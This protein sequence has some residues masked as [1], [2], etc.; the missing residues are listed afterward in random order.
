MNSKLLLCLALV[1]S[2]GLFGCSITKSALIAADAEQIKLPITF[3]SIGDFFTFVARD[4]INGMPINDDTVSKLVADSTDKIVVLDSKQRQMPF[5]HV[6]ESH[7][8]NRGIDEIR[9]VQGNGQFYILRPLASKVE[10]VGILDGNSYRL[11]PIN[12]TPRFVSYW[13]LSA[14][15][16]S[17]NI[18]EWNGK[19]FEQKK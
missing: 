7:Y 17:E 6:V 19:F 13:H 5:V 2:G 16:S 8:F 14:N 11:Q 18:Y 15:E 12:G 1:L 9:G 4:S 3:A 10:L